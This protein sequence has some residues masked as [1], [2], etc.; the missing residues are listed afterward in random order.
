MVKEIAAPP[1]KST[2]RGFG[3]LTEATVLFPAI[4]LVLLA[5]IWSATVELARLEDSNAAHVAAL[6]SRELLGTYEAQVVRALREI[7]QTLSLVKYWHE[8]ARSGGTLAELKDKG[9]LPPDLLFTVS[10]A[11][12]RGQIVDSTRPV[13]E[14]YIADQDVFRAQREAETL[15]IGQ[16]AKGRV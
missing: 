13:E 12:R 15:F 5:L 8:S 6:S 9:L 3:R 7:D 10:V 16:P 14:R 2:R 1:G 4:A 11:D